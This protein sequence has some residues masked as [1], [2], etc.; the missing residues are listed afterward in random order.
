M[1]AAGCHCV[2][3]RSTNSRREGVQVTAWSSE[4]TVALVVTQSITMR[5]VWRSKPGRAEWHSRCRPHRQLSARLAPP[6]IPTIYRRFNC[7]SG[8][9][10]E[11]H[12]QSIATWY[13][14]SRSLT[15]TQPQTRTATALRE[16]CAVRCLSS[17]PIDTPAAA[18]G[19]GGRRQRQQSRQR[20]EHQQQQ[21]TMEAMAEAMEA[22]EGEQDIDK[23]VEQALACPC[24]GGLGLGLW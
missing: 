22:A 7:T 21:H 4:K 11:P 24:L 17:K 1:R 14:A 16:A 9:A 3:G 6:C 12:T 8:P 10:R 20:P 2:V 18:G 19:S 13:S 23:K 15:A 5:V